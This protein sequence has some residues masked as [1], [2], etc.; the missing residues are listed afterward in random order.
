MTRRKNW[1]LVSLVCLPS[2]VAIASLTLLNSPATESVPAADAALPQ[3]AAADVS[4]AG[5]VNH[6]A[7]GFEMPPLTAVSTRASQPQRF[8]S[9]VDE[10]P[11]MRVA[12]REMRTTEADAPSHAAGGSQAAGSAAH[13]TPH[14]RPFGHAL[15]TTPYTAGL[16]Q[17]GSNVDS[18]EAPRG[19]GNAPNLPLDPPQ[20]PGTSPQVDEPAPP[21]SGPTPDAPQVP[22]VDDRQK[23]TPPPADDQDDS[24]PGTPPIWNL[25]PAPE[26]PVVPVPEPSTFILFGIG[27]LGVALMRRKRQQ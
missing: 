20:E 5:V 25:P 2:A 19:G 27:A 15:R 16:G 12:A 23:E 13:G 26:Q 10:Q 11:L 6:Q 24:T 4:A 3:P 8:A 18:T 17:V 1:M 22:P 9:T 14:D 21:Q 7:H